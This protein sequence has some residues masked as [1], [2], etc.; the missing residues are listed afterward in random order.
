MVTVAKE[1]V[2]ANIQETQHTEMQTGRRASIWVDTFPGHALHTHVDSLAPATGVA[3]AAIQPDNATGNF[4][5][6]V[7]RVPVK[8][9]I[10][11]GQPLSAKLRVGM[12]VEASV[13]TGSKPSGLHAE[14]ARDAWREKSYGQRCTALSRR[15]YRWP[16]IASVR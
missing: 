8:L 12:S 5:K 1:Y 9:T 4:T 7:Q 6:V 16:G 15:M 11:P 14:D 3:F 13:D 10:D 2:L